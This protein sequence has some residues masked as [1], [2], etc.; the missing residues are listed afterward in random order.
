MY[1]TLNAS[2]SYSSGTNHDAFQRHGEDAKVDVQS[3]LGN[4]DG[5]DEGY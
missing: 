2:F 5:K 4:F 3:R 1:L